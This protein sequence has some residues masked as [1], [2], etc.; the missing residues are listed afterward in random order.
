M[1]K[2]TLDDPSF[3]RK[4]KYRYVRSGSTNYRITYYSDEFAEV[5][6]KTAFDRKYRAIRDFFGE[7]SH[8]GAYEFVLSEVSN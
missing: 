5:F 3:Y 6:I 7:A 1:A 2:L 4:F 8:S